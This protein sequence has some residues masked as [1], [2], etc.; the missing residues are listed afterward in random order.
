MRP[1][2]KT[3][4]DFNRIEFWG[5][6]VIYILS[7]FLLVSQGVRFGT[8]DGWSDL[9]YAFI[10]R[11]YRFSYLQNFLIPKAAT[12]TALY[13][14]YIFLG[15]YITPNIQ[16]RNNLAI[17]IFLGILVFALLGL[18]MSISDT[19]I[20]AYEMKDHESLNA[21][22]NDVFRKRML[23]AFWMMFLFAMYIVIK[24][25]AVYILVNEDA[26]QE[27]Y[28]GLTREVIIIFI[29]W[30]IS[31]FLLL[32]AGA[33]ME[34][35]IMYSVIIPIAIGLY[36]YSLHKL[37]P[38]VLHHPKRKFLKYCWKVFQ[39]LLISTLPLAMVILPIV[40]HGEAVV[41]V[42][43]GNAAIQLFVTAPIS[44]FMYKYKTENKTELVYLRQALGTS[45]ANLDLLKSQINPHFLFNSLNTLYG[46]ALQEKAD[47]TSEGIQRLGDMMR[48]MLEENV[49][50][51]ISL[52]REI[53]YIKNYI[54]L[55][56]LRTQESPNIII[57]ENIEDEP[58]SLYITPMLLIPFIENAF[59]HGISLREPSHIKISLNTDKGSIF[60]DV[61]NS[62]H[63]RENDPEKNNTGIGLNN[64]K[65]R[66]NMFYPNKHELI[67]RENAK[68]FFIHL[69]I[70]LTSEE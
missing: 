58:N 22:Y 10:E 49:Q 45:S 47:R 56:K 3:A 2:T 32:V 48:F 54:S 61:Y 69:T 1:E 53:D 65:Q 8:D 50:D 13:G 17:N 25:F 20:K 52:N 57:Q 15:L 27:K 68:E 33:H 38:S 34:I 35:I 9:S 24:H 63:T 6:T 18:V 62:I 26:I 67:I 4:F 46:T 70:Q 39:I 44:W 51:R 40:N 64:V 16:R 14:A 42:L 19:W 36:W 7:I 11:N 28:K 21:F 37:I 30:M 66:L 29:L 31:F 12:Y 60:F 41:A 59:K 55:Q 23:F 5:A 43:T